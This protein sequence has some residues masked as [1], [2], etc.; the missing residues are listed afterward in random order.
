MIPWS[1]ITH[2]N[3]SLLGREFEN[4]LGLHLCESPPYWMNWIKENCDG[5]KKLRK[6]SKGVRK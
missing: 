1:W 5:T 2:F 3:K 6:N 4:D